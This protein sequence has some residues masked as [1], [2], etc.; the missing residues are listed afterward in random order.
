MKNQSPLLP[1]TKSLRIMVQCAI[2][3]AMGTVLSLIP[4][5][6]PWLIWGGSLTPLSMLPICLIGL[7][8]GPKWGLGS[9]FIFS[10]FQL[11]IGNCFAWGLTPAVLVICIL[12]DYIV[13]YS[14]LG[15][16]GFFKG[17]S[18]IT[19]CVGIGAAVLL[20]MVC[21]YITGVTIWEATMPEEFTNVWLYSLVYNGSY[22]LP[23]TIL[24]VLGGFAVLSVPKLWNMLKVDKAK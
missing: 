23:E 8:N 19:M 17:R 7:L 22:M 5:P 10:V 20:R 16:T 13:A 11:L 9:A 3:I 14:V 6:M 12:F 24:T 18:K 2:L 4:I 1:R 15:I 21:H